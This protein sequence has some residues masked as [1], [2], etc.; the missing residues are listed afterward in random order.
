MNVPAS[1]DPSKDQTRSDLCAFLQKLGIRLNMPQITI[2][3]A[4]VF[5]HRFF[6]KYSF[7]EQPPESVAFACLFL[8]SKIEESPVR[9]KDLIFT[10]LVEKGKTPKA[11]SA[12]YEWWRREILK[13]ERNVLQ[14]LGFDF[15]IE[16]PYANMLTKVKQLQNDNH[17]ILAQFAW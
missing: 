15:Q 2:A 14:I 3:S 1:V 8:A 13:K 4:I 6:C 11:E 12:E 9:L 10:M 7:E 5:F 16:H 17:K